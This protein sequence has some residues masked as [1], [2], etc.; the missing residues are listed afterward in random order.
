MKKIVTLV[1]ALCFAATASGSD[2]PQ[3]QIHGFLSQG[4]LISDDNDYLYANTSEGTFQFNEF[5][6]SFST[7]LSDHLRA[8]IQLL[9]RDLGDYGNNKL[10]V[11]WASGDYRYRN[12]FG[13]RA[14]ILKIDYGLFNLSRDIDAARPPIFLPQTI[15]PETFRDTTK[16][17]TGI[18]LYG[19]L[20]AGFGYSFQYGKLSIDKD[21]SFAKAVGQGYTDLETCEDTRIASL[22]WATPLDGLRFR[23]AIVDNVEITNPGA[24][25]EMLT[26]FYI[27]SGEYLI[28][29]FSVAAEYL[30]GTNEVSAIS[31][32]LLKEYD[33]EGYYIMAG[34]RFLEWFQVGSYYSVSYLDKD[35]RDGDSFAAQELPRAMAWIK[36]TAVF[37]RF[38]V[39]DNW[40]FKVEGHHIDGLHRWVVA[41]PTETDDTGFLF[42][43]KVTF[44]F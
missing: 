38:D 15:Y 33:I 16:S 6:V 25:I 43:A 8:G 34:Y 35:D 1:L 14:G 17:I 36:D 20:P 22:E 12:W 42:A 21:E 31:G 26:R 13:V 41:S 9:S 2:M 40:I 24:G 23:C 39:T 10:V 27:G 37:G 5:G 11:D 30:Y 44:S 19:S 3:V 29:D 7:E 18:G 32:P 4:Y 28:G